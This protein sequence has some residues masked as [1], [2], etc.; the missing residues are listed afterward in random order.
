MRP[1][2]TELTHPQDDGQ[3]P[4]DPDEALGLIPDWVMTR[5]DLNL[6]EERN[7]TQGLRW[8][9]RTRQPVLTPEF[10]RELHRRLFA[11]VWRWAG[12]YRDSERNIGVAPHHIA[13]ELKKLFD[14][15]E[16]WQRFDSYTID[17]RAARL[18][19][20]LT[21]IHPFPNGN[22]RCARI[23]ADLYLVREGRD[24]FS[25]GASLPELSRRA[26]YL[27]AIRL[28]DTHDYAALLAFAR[29]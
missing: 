4:L 22:G 2:A 27:R 11:R 18:H 8:V 7:I 23:F 19:H 13:T 6:A 12:R 10:L 3:T 14:D 28:A 16:A 24:A 17:E 26:T 25:W 15:A 1:G 20:R 5:A 9:R 29:A 21:A